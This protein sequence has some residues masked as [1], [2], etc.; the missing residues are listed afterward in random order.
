MTEKLLYQVFD[1]QRFAENRRLQK[2]IDRV[3]R[4]CAE[5]ELSDDELDMVSAAGAP[6]PPVKKKGSRI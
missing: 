4:Q 5:R 1:L 6:Q 2:T 3:H